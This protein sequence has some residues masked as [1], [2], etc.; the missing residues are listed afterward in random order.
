MCRQ[1]PDADEKHCDAD[2]QRERHRHGNGTQN[3]ADDRQ[4]PAGRKNQN[5]FHRAPI[6]KDYRLGDAKCNKRRELT[7]MD[8]LPNVRAIFG[9]N[10]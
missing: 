3:R 8:L 6:T 9:G 10:T 2:R 5:F 7:I 1:Y 4:E